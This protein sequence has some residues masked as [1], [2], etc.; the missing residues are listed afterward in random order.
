MCRVPNN[1][2]A[3]LDKL[4]LQQL[5]QFFQVVAGTKSEDA[6]RKLKDFSI[7]QSH[8]TKYFE[9]RYYQVHYKGKPVKMFNENDGPPQLRN[10]HS[11]VNSKFWTKNFD[12]FVKGFDALQISIPATQTGERSVQE[13]LINC[14]EGVFYDDDKEKNYWR[15]GSHWYQVTGK[16]SSDVYAEYASIIRT[17]LL[18][19]S[20]CSLN[21][22]WPLIEGRKLPVRSCD[23]RKYK[24]SR[25][26]Y[27]GGYCKLYLKA[28]N[29]LIV[30][31][32]EVVIFGVEICDFFEFIP[33]PAGSRSTIHLH[34]V[35]KA[36]GA[37]GYRS[38]FWQLLKS[39]NYL[40]DSIIK[41]DASEDSASYKLF[42]FIQKNRKDQIPV[43]ATYEEFLH[44]LR[45]ATFVFSPLFAS[46][47]R[48]L[49]KVY[50][51]LPKYDFSDFENYIDIAFREDLA[52]KL[53]SFLLGSEYIYESDGV[54]TQKW[55]DA[56]SVIND[57]GFHIKN[58]AGFVY[59]PFPGKKI[60]NMS[61]SQLRKIL[62]A[63]Y[64]YKSVDGLSV[65][66]IIVRCSAE[67]K[68]MGFGFKI[69]Q[70]EG[71]GDDLL[72]DD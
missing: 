48:E 59:D 31:D 41:G 10:M 18:Q 60:S 46:G 72:G 22:L 49:D 4:L 58:D 50:M 3:E 24:D 12:S 56:C 28:P 9:A 69:C 62:K 55:Y 7:V 71:E 25:F 6:F 45:D 36:F 54:F 68:C 47:E 30:T 27:E 17:S 5:H 43:Y 13:K 34:F 61:G 23:R 53:H 2:M 51:T 33:N 8:N 15:V 32:N 44:Y 52:I 14:L 66:Q 29:F 11:I 57:R 20:D 63:K 70:I 37:D 35:K 42:T 19:K 39:A 26:I 65:K 64:Y 16:Y 67:L 38:V 21:V 40:F 1:R